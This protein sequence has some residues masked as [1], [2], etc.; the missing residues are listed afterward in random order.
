MRPLLVLRP[1]PGAEATCARARA[2]GFEAIKAPLFRIV[3]LAWT[4]PA[5][6]IDAVMLTSANAV[7]HG[8]SAA[9]AG[10]PAFVVGAATAAAARAA[11]F[12]DVRDA[13]GDG[14]ALLALVE[15]ERPGRMLHLIGRDHLP[16]D[17]A[18]VEIVRRIA[19]AAE[20]VQALPAAAA[21]ALAREAIALLHSPRAAA[22]FAALADA[23]GIA[24]AGI[25]IAAISRAA[26]GSGWRAQAIA[27]RPDDD[28][29]LAA[30]AELCDR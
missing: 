22:R 5:G 20:P 11:G 14:A 13:G 12:R 28:A 9:R 23:A 27:A 3:P 26:A 24:R 29:L 7:R 21:A 15:R 16:L 6:R 4:M 30:A 18:T 10:L 2:L 25:A 17:S 19:Y 1:E 8:G